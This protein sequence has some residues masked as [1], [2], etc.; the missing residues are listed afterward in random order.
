MGKI[1]KGTKVWDEKGLH[2]PTFSVYCSSTLSVRNLLLGQPLLY[3]PEPRGRTDPRGGDEGE[4]EAAA[5]AIH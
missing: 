1:G 5:R 4:L 2:L 3:S